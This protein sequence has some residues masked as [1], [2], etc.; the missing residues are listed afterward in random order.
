MQCCHGRSN[1]SQMC[2][3]GE[4][5]KWEPW[6]PRGNRFPALGTRIFHGGFTLGWRPCRYTLCKCM[7]FD[8]PA[9]AAHTIR[10]RCERRKSA[11]DYGFARASIASLAVSALAASD[12]QLPAQNDWLEPE[13]HWKVNLCRA[14]AD[15]KVD[16]YQDFMRTSITSTTGDA[17]VNHRSCWRSSLFD[18]RGAA[19]LCSAVR[20]RCV[21]HICRRH[22]HVANVASMRA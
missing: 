15:T 22:A 4:Y 17:A 2:G 6:E 12:R 9:D 20:Y 11:L 14:A 8:C 7:N 16:L 10:R 21:A 18:E 1:A 13:T 19:S 3:T 5:L